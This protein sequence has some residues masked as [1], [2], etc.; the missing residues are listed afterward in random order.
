LDDLGAHKA[1]L[2][3]TLLTRRDALPV[4]QRADLSR[5]ITERLLQLPAVTGARAVLAYASFGSEFDTNALVNAILASGKQLAL[6]RV[7]RRARRLEL[8]FVADCQRD[9]APGVW[10]ILEPAPERCRP[11]TLNEVDLVLAPGVA[12]S[13]H[14][15]RL[16]YGGGYYDRLLAGRPATSIAVAAA[17]D[18]QVVATLPL[19]PADVPVDL[20]VTET[21]TYRRPVS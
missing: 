17:F 18:L 11:A 9:L 20:L 7:D 2:R 16:G 1:A 4:A 6:P 14:C 8:Y 5:R 13:P 21:A 3:Q 15:E 12:F 19:G 10:G